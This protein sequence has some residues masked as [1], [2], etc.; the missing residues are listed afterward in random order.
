MLSWASPSSC[1]CLSSFFR[2]YNTTTAILRPGKRPRPTNTSGSLKRTRQ[3][4]VQRKILQRAA[5][6]QAQPAKEP[7]SQAAAPAASSIAPHT[8]PDENP[9]EAA[10]PFAPNTF[11]S[12]SHPKAYVKSYTPRTPG[13]RHLRRVVNEHLW[14]GRPYL[15]LT[16]PKKGISRG[17]RNNTGRITVRHRGGGHARRIRTLDFYRHAPGPQ[18]VL[19]I[20]YD[21][22]RSAHIALLQHDQSSQKTYIVAPDGMQAGDKVESFMAGIP[23]QLMQEMGGKIDLGLLAA[24]TVKRGNCLPVHYIPLGMQVYNVGITSRGRARLCRSAGTFATIFAKD[25]PEEG[26]EAGRFV[27]IRLRSGEIRKVSSWSPASIGTA[28][29]PMYNFRQLGKAGRSRW[30]GI[31]PTVRGVAMNTSGYFRT[32]HLGS[33][34]N[35]AII[36]TIIH[37]EVAEENPRAT[38]S[39]RAPRVYQYV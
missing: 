32:V 9:V 8:P 10:S 19:R 6:A 28:S 38:A 2:S 12:D 25:E 3:K 11:G 23:D 4:K 14:T 39:R 34:A 5:R 7:S 1:S 35:T 26:Q 24:K 33:F 20:E 13:V 27:S 37:T 15:P 16:Y 30:L 29:N 21:P 18:T 31:R 22:N 36:Q 17:G